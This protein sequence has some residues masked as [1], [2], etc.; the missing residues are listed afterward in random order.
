MPRCIPVK[1]RDTLVCVGKLV[2]ARIKR[3]WTTYK[4]ALQAGL[5]EHQVRHAERVE[6]LHGLARLHVRTAV[7]LLELYHPDLAL[8]DLVP[9]TT[10]KV[11]RAE[12][13][14]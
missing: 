12:V 8:Q 9:D 13:S 6:D 2:D 4:A 5:L 1:R 3:G 7:R 11:S 10:L 14:E